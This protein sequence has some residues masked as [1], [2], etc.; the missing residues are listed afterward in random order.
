MP[1]LSSIPW[2]E[3]DQSDFFYWSKEAREGRSRD[4]KSATLFPCLERG[5]GWQDYLAEFQTTRDDEAEDFN[6]FSLLIDLKLVS[7]Q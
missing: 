2:N 4:R 3:S 5:L 7:F 6:P 1:G